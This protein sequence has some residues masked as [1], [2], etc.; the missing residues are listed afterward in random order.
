[1]AEET[2]HSSHCSTCHKNLGHALENT[3]LNYSDKF[4]FALQTNSL[5]DM[6]K[7]DTTTPADGLCW[8]H[9]IVQQMQQQ[10]VRDY[11]P[12]S[13]RGLTCGLQLKTCLNEWINQNII[14]LENQESFKEL[15]N[16][17][18]EEEYGT[19]VSSYL[20]VIHRQKR[21][22]EW[23]SSLHTQLTCSFLRVK[24]VI[25]SAHMKITEIWPMFPLTPVNENDLPS[26]HVAFFGGDGK[27][28]PHYQSVIRKYDASAFSMT[29]STASAITGS[30]L[31]EDQPSSPKIKCESC[32]RVFPTNRSLNIHIGRS[33]VC[34]DS[35]GEKYAME[36]AN[37]KR[38]RNK[39]H[40]EKN[41]DKIRR[42]QANYRQDMAEETSIKQKAHRKEH[43]EDIKS[44]E[45]VYRKENKAKINETK[46]KYRQV[47]ATNIEAYREKNRLKLRD[48]Q[49]LYNSMK[50]DSQQK[51][52][53]CFKQDTRDGLSF[54][55]CCC[56]RLLGKN[57]VIEVKK[58][59]LKKWE[60]QFGSQFLHK[61]MSMTKEMAYQ[62]KHYLCCNCKRN[63]ASGTMPAIC[64][65]NGLKLDPVPSE[66]MLTD[67]E[68]QLIAPRLLFMKIKQ[69]PKSRM[70]GIVDRV[71]DVPLESK[72]I[73]E[74]IAKMPRM[75][76]KSATTFV[77]LKRMK[78][79]KNTHM[80][81]YIRPRAVVDAL[82]KLKEL[83][84]PFFTSVE[85]PSTYIT[86]LEQELIE[87]VEDNTNSNNDSENS[88]CEMEHDAG[89]HQIASETTLDPVKRHQVIIADHT[90]LVPEDP[91][92]MVVVNN[93]NTSVRT[94]SENNAV[95]EI[96]PGEGKIPTNWLKDENFDVMA[97]PC[98]F[99]SG[100]FGLFHQREKK[101]S[102]QQYFNQ[103][104]L[105][106]DPR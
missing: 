7:L 8:Y 62:G 2:Y 40:Y 22:Y 89:S 48:N 46:A 105:N 43:A 77:K 90:G 102:S 24:I 19:D 66:L 57:S 91:A 27:L 80:E 84:N 67:L 99:P 42:K 69:L 82:E 41:K 61:T 97:F 35:Y 31:T 106:R 56:Q 79:M 26:I 60:K 75:I 44:K 83:Q 93:S 104:I 92:G 70:A 16:Y 15:G 12:V 100:Q 39:D 45:A 3:N 13:L 78:S 10:H 81:A 55:C 50:K 20:D 72:D 11:L 53:L 9:A 52:A 23:V 38:Q 94:V 59:E 85:V 49:A 32:K 86:D 21:K 87:I 65:A 58:K 98:L 4:Q 30:T 64:V 29:G 54:V 88:E 74:T 76:S 25:V 73:E 5:S 18:A 68:N 17:V 71:I 1:M 37:R 36:K 96:A 95:F 34:R 14:F 47:Q 6:F 51:R 103:R 63:L 101:I 33:S 28:P